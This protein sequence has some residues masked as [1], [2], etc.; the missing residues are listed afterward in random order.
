MSDKKLA[1]LKVV[2]HDDGKAYHIRPLTTT[3]DE[4]AEYQCNQFERI[5]TLVERREE[6][7]LDICRRVAN[8]D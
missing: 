5:A 4:G 6:S 8:G 7:F 3:I 1:E 2:I